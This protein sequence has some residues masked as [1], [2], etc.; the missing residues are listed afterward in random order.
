[1]KNLGRIFAI[2]LLGAS[3][4][5]RAQETLPVARI[6]IYPGD[7]IIEQMLDDRPFNLTP[8]TETVYARRRDALIGK[9]AR[10]TL[11]PGQPI[12]MIAID[13]PRIVTIGA[14]IKIL[15]IE[16]GLQIVAYGIAQQAGG[17]GDFIRVRNQDSGI[18]I[19]GRIQSDGSVRVGEG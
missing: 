18:F 11:L 3:A 8:G 16:D 6:T 14:Q 1:M 19:S 12:P 15:F 10:R 2:A 7:P 13:N 5:A 9:I 4:P 17:V